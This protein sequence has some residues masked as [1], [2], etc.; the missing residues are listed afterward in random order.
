MA[1]EPREETPLEDTKLAAAGK[2]I[3][4][5]G[6][7]VGET[8]NNVMTAPQRAGKAVADFLMQPST[9][10]VEGVPPMLARD[11]GTNT[12]PP[13]LEQEFTPPPAQVV[14][15]PGAPVNPALQADIQQ[16]RAEQQSAI[17][18]SATIEAETQ[19]KLA[20]VEAERA[21]KIENERIV[22]ENAAEKR[23]LAAEVEMKKIR[24]AQ[25]ELDE[26][27]PPEDSTGTKIGKMFGIM[28]SAFGSAIAGGS[29]KALDFIE[30][31]KASKLTA[32]KAQYAR[33]QGKVANAQNMYAQL[34]QRGLDDQAAEAATVQKLN[35]RYASIA[36]RVAAEGGGPRVLAEADRVIAAMREQNK[37]NDRVLWERA[38]GTTKVIPG[39]APVETQNKLLK[40]VDDDKLIAGWR[41]KSGALSKFE[42]LVSAGADGA[43][44]ADFIAGKGGLEQGSFGPNFVE[45]MKKRS[46]FGK[47]VEQLRET[48]QGGIDPAILKD[49]RTGLALETAAALQRA[50]PRIK[51]YR[52][53][54]NQAGIDPA[55]VTGGESSA[56]A[57]AEVGATPSAYQ[58]KK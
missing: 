53:T 30:Q 15:V 18:K 12:N 1:N 45:M 5:A 17:A 37:V 19:N 47:S 54:F 49:I 51:H 22:A 50:A 39:G 34:R 2:A 20:A 40:A 33:G 6:A 21:Q 4:D 38:Q 9:P 58:G 43:A 26:I 23:R 8:V 25:K 28:F 48:F 24:D 14:R 57:A 35:E 36:R 11:F 32:W 10:A 16:A 52:R 7:N 29:N 13:P 42:N 56:D 44:L 46:L 41:E 27:A 31:D 3:V 55:M